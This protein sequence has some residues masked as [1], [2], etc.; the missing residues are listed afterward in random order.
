MNEAVSISNN[1]Y[2]KLILIL[3]VLFV[4][5][6]C[7]NKTVEI[8]VDK[9]DYNT[10]ITLGD[11]L[12]L[13]FKSNPSTGYKWFLDVNDSNKLILIDDIYI[14]NQSKKN[15]VGSGGTFSIQYIAKECGVT[16][17]LA[18]YMRP[19]EKDLPANKEAAILVNIN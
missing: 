19:F 15:V 10:N 8:M 12:K 11:T 1:L 6:S 5:L 14:A 3:P 18:R 16:K 7:N 17:I 9:G 4:L 13:N 2:I